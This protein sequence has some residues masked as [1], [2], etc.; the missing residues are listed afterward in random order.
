MTSLTEKKITNILLTEAPIST[1]SRN[2]ELMRKTTSEKSVRSMIQTRF[3]IS[4]LDKKIGQSKEIEGYN[5]KKNRKNTTT[6][7]IIM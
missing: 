1:E 4:E 5:Q 2:L 3:G 6:M 7:E